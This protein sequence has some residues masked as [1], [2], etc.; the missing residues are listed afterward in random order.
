MN[1]KPTQR[2]SATRQTCA[3]L[4]RLVRIRQWDAR[5]AVLGAVA[6]IAISGCGGSE[7]PPADS[8]SLEV[9]AAQ[10]HRE[11]LVIDTE[12]DIRFDLFDTPERNPSERSDMQFDLYKMEEGGVDAAVFVIFAS[13]DRRTPEGYARTYATAQKKL[14]AIHRMVEDNPDRIEIARNADDVERIVAAGK[15]AALIGMVNG[16]ALGPELEELDRYDEAGLV[17]IAFTHA[18]HNQLSDSARP[19]EANEDGETEHGGLSQLGGSS[20]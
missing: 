8:L 7:T 9:R 12:I 10:L 20:S 15:R 5:G 17:Y 4:V 11:V 16:N 18:G 13:Q 2:S 3:G 6:S 19:S 14:A 1:S